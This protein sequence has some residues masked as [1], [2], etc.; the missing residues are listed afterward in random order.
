MVWTVLGNC[1]HSI[2][3]AISALLKHFELVVIQACI[4]DVQQQCKKKY[5]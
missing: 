4:E 3:Q 2:R 1:E 5:S